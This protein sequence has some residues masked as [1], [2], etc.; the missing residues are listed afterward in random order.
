M[1]PEARWQRPT[2]GASLA[3]EAVGVVE[4]D[5]LARVTMS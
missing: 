3:R 2:A 5:G 1:Q 4:D